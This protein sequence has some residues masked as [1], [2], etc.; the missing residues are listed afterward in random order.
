[1]KYYPKLLSIKMCKEKGSE[2]VTNDSGELIVGYGLKGDAYS[3]PGDREVCIMS[4]STI[5]KLSLC[6]EGLCVKRFVETLCID[7][8]AKVLDI[9]D[10]LVLSDAEVII[11]QKGKKC[12]SEC[13]LL[14]KKKYCPLKTEPIFG[15]VIKGGNISVK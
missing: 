14:Q 8:D 1:M 3:K 12:F 5:D 15:R 6:R 9:N 4:K 7:L 10:I 11:T 2:R 13:I